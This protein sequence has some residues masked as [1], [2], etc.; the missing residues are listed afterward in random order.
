MLRIENSAELARWA[1]AE[2]DWSDGKLPPP[3]SSAFD[4]LR[5]IDVSTTTRFVA[6]E[7]L[8]D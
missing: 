3:R 7:A 5:T 6:G 4:Q 1:M 2:D 8:T